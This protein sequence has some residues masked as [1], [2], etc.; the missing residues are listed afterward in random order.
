LDERGAFHPF[1][2][3]GIEYAREND[4]KVDANEYATKNDNQSLEYSC[5]SL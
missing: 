1:E 4:E 3:I 5:G 2:L